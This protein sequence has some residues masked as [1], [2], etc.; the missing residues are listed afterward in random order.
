MNDLVLYDKDTKEVLLVEYGL[1]N[2]ALR[3]P[4]AASWTG[5][6]IAA[7]P[8]LIAVVAADSS[9]QVGDTYTGD[10]ADILDQYPSAERMKELLAQARQV[11]TTMKEDI[12][13]LKTR[14]QQLNQQVQDLEARVTTLEG[15]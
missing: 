6:S 2:V 13:L 5:G 3:G 14:G 11:I 8:N 9:I 15:L 4:S 1:S 12:E 10:V 7:S